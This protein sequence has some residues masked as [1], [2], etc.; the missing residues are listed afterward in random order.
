MKPSHLL[1][2]RKFGFYG[3]TAGERETNIKM[4]KSL[5][6]SKCTENQKDPRSSYY[7]LL[8]G[9]LRIYS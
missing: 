9:V 7:K 4:I 5:V 1:I 8:F 3:K 2:G 6:P